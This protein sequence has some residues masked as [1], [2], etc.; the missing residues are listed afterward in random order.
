M[1]GDQSLQETLSLIYHLQSMDLEGQRLRA[2]TEMATAAIQTE[3]AHL[4][5]LERS[6]EIAKEE[7]RT[8]EMNHQKIETD[9]KDTELLLLEGKKRQKD[10]KHARDIQAF[11]SEAEFRRD[12]K[13]RME[14]EIIANLEAQ[15][16]L[17]KRIESLEADL[18]TKKEVYRQ[19][20]DRF[21]TE[22]EER[23]QRIEE[24]EKARKDLEKGFDE[25]LLETYQ[26]LRSSQKNGQVIT[27]V[28]DGACESCRITLPPRT[29]TEVKKRKQ[30]MSC[31]Y[32]QRWLYIE[33]GKV[34]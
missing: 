25:D 24:I 20:T 6:L 26:R 8:L 34:S 30:I 4:E 16:S 13:D 12:E 22:T 1:S 31:Q 19:E 17:A 2:Q 33:D 27:R 5:S 14:E 28:I 32:C 18:A 9:L 3:K 23:K 7:L 21:A 29:V 15:S 10:L 11:L